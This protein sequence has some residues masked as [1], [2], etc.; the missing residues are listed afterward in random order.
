MAHILKVY[1]LITLLAALLLTTHPAP[2]AEESTSDTARQIAELE[3]KRAERLKWIVTIYDARGEQ[4]KA[5]PYIERLFVLDSANLKLGAR[6]MKTLRSQKRLN[7]MLDLYKRI[8]QAYPHPKRGERDQLYIC[9]NSICELCDELRRQGRSKEL[10]PI[11]ERL[12]TLVPGD[13]PNRR[14]SWGGLPCGSFHD[15]AGRLGMCYKTLCESRLAGGDTKGALD[16]LRTYRESCHSYAVYD[17]SANFLMRHGQLEEACTVLEEALAGQYKNDFIMLRQLGEAYTR[18]DRIDKAIVAYETLLDKATPPRTSLRDGPVSLLATLYKRA[19]AFDKLEERT[20][21][22]LS[23]EGVDFRAM[24]DAGS[25]FVALGSA[26]DN[27]HSKRFSPFLR[28]PDDRVVGQLVYKFTRG[29]PENYY[30]P[31]LLEALDCGRPAVVRMA[32]R[33]IFDKEPRPTVDNRIR[34]FFE[35][36]DETLKLNACY[37][38]IRFYGD[39]EAILYVLQ[40]VESMDRE[41]AH[42]AGFILCCLPHTEKTLSQ[43]VLEKARA[44][45]S[46]KEKHHR[47]AAIRAIG[48]YRGEEA[49]SFLIGALGVAKGG[50]S[51]DPAWDRITSE[52]RDEEMVSRLLEAAL[53][54]RLEAR[55]STVQMIESAL[56]NIEQRQKKRQTEGP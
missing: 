44:L 41:R 16:L 33:A 35:G 36:D 43:A 19:G 53:K 22:I 5:V 24:N 9:S 55:D 13:R 30:P 20:L 14:S 50:G 27:R 37:R 40:E 17:T 4:E 29:S 26:C 7:E 32:I 34:K 46:S 38:L 6:L 18:L 31:L 51:H 8:A 23:A 10:I 48:T 2:A 15:V 42:R 52:G 25:F 49:V 12:L 28:H 3:Q 45:L 39:E 1:V 54:E 11:Y 47:E 56:K 21:S